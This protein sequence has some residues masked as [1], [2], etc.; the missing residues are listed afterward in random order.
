M[1]VNRVR[2][3][4]TDEPSRTVHARLA[5]VGLHL[6]CIRLSAAQRSDRGLRCSVLL[7][8]SRGECWRRC[9]VARHMDG[10]HR[11]FVRCVRRASIRS[12][13][14]RRR[15]NRRLFRCLGVAAG[16]VWLGPRRGRGHSRDPRSSARCRHTAGPGGRVPLQTQRTGLAAQRLQLDFGSAPRA[17]GTAVAL[18]GNTLVISAPHFYQ[19]PYPRGTLFVHART[20]A[21]WVCTHTLGDIPGQGGLASEPH[22]L[23][24]SG[25]TFV[26]GAPD[27]GAPFRDTGAAW[28]CRRFNGLWLLGTRLANAATSAGTRFGASVAV[29]GDDVLI[30]APGS[31]E[32]RGDAFVVCWTGSGCTPRTASLHEQPPARDL[33]RPMQ[34]TGC[35]S[36][37][38]RRA[39]E[40]T[41]E[42]TARRPPWARRTK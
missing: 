38:R 2:A 24:V 41:P 11:R 37:A 40:E 6:R 28:V 16:P 20:D 25:D 21:G 39:C 22:N 23:A 35:I 36:S 34:R 12:H 18:D 7:T 4:R 1:R 33:V 13:I 29:T 42:S 15:A 9:S 5:G 19:T 14:L 17:L 26:A 30:G 10:I 8:A 27:K 3:L 32:G 31:Q